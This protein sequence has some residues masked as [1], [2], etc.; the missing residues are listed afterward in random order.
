[1]EPTSGKGQKVHMMMM[2]MTFLTFQSV[3]PDD[4]KFDLELREMLIDQLNQY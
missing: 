2:M 4:G 1:M 3:G